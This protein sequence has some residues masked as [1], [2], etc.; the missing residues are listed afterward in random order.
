MNRIAR[1][2]PNGQTLEISRDL[3]SEWLPG[4]GSVGVS[5]SPYTALDAA[6]LLASLDRYPYGCPSRYLARDAALALC[7]NRAGM[8]ENLALVAG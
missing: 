7:E 2:I 3:L 1:P 6:G 5:A 4:S 8:Q